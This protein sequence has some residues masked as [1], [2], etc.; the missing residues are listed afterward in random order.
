MFSLHTLNLTIIAIW[1]ITFDVFRNIC[2]E[3]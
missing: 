2:L 1:W 3:I